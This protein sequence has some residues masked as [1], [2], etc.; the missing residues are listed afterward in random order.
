MQ[1]F[2]KEWG[3]HALFWS[4]YLLIK[5][6]VVEFFREDMTTVF[7]IELIRLPLKML[8]VYLL[9]YYLIPKFLLHKE[10]LTFM[11]WL[12]L[13]VV[14]AA[15]ARRVMDIYIT[16]PI[17]MLYTDRAIFW[18]Y[19]TA[20]RNLVFIYPVVGLGT[21][22]YLMSHWI[23]DYHLRT[24]L[25]QEKLRAELQYLK[26]QVHPHF[27]FNT[28]NNI[29]SLSLDHSPKTS[30]SLLELSDLLSYMLYECNAERMPL[31]KELELIENYINLEK[32]RY[33]ERLDLKF[34]TKGAVDSVN[35]APLI[36]LPFVD[37]C[38]KHGAGDTMTECFVHFDLEVNQGS[39]YLNLAN[40][41]PDKASAHSQNSGI[42]L[43][44]VKRRLEGEYPNQYDLE[45]NEEQ[46]VYQVK[47]KIDIDAKG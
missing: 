45:I 3:W 32:L 6:F 4:G 25:Q 7:Y 17:G 16:Y 18:D 42:G 14:F 46:D 27:L 23:R 40:S 21:A 28:I 36:L 30:R 2:K 22:I 37:N 12:V 47:L 10:Y 35:I 1:E 39:L 41:I 29:Y 13:L 11:V 33:S 8:L 20:F 9:I 19:G 15:F 34:E 24:Q 44:N 38:F 5:I 31:K 43:K 26:A